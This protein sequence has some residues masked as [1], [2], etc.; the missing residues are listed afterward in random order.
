M[1]VVKDIY[2]AAGDEK[3]IRAEETKVSLYALGQEGYYDH[4]GWLFDVQNKKLRYGAVE[5]FLLYL[6]DD[7]TPAYIQGFLEGDISRVI[8]FYVI[9]DKSGK[10]SGTISKEEYF[11]HHN[12][13]FSKKEF[14]KKKFDF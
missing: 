14:V 1:Q 10:Y 4:D 7:G 3:T 5:S 9:K 11:K 13:D 6:L 12:F 8:P 2:K